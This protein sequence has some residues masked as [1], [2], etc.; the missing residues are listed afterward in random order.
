MRDMEHIVTKKY[1]QPFVVDISSLRYH[2]YIAAITHISLKPCNSIVNPYLG[3]TNILYS[4][5]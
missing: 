1:A 4:N 5:N 3:E 2:R